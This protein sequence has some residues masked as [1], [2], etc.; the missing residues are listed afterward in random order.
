MMTTTSLSKLPEVS[1][2]SQ[3]VKDY[4]RVRSESESIC[5]PLEIED[6]GL[7]T[8]DDVSPPKWHLAHV[9][10]FFETFILKPFSNN[11]KE[12]NPQFAHLFNSYYETVGT[13]HPRP[14]R[15]LLARPTVAEVYQ[16]RAHVDDAMQSLLADESHTQYKE[17]TNRTIL[18]L[19]HEQQ[20]QE[21]LFTDIKHI[22]AYSPLHPVYQNCD[23]PHVDNIA[24]IGWLDIDEGVCETGHAGEGFAYDNE[25]PRHKN[26]LNGSRVANRLVTNGE[27]IEFINAGAYQQPQWWLSEGWKT[28]Q[29]QNWSAPLYW[30]KQGGVWWYTTLSGFKPV[31]HNAP[32]CHV[33]LYEADAYARWA[34]KRLPSEIEWEFLAAQRE[35]K[36]NLRDQQYY[37]PIAGA[38]NN[39]QFYGDVWEWT[40]TSYSPYPGYVTPPG[41][42]GE[43]NGKFMSSQFVLRGGSCVTP[44]EH[45]RATYRNFFYPGDRW[46]FSGIRLAEDK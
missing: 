27:F 3:L 9:S 28:V 20:H 34:G 25:F 38:N 42:I 11:Y 39:E 44:Q 32:V 15:G 23:Y 12:F 43:Y 35:I 36:G 29:Q 19:H 1:T 10:W 26:Y 8:I 6:Y 5:A 21:L 18:G 22:F 16:Y 2:A 7:Q 17:I 30:Q 40:Q 4:L 41:A 45:I 24:P 37:Q 33:S 46:Q 14:E 31:D 13:F